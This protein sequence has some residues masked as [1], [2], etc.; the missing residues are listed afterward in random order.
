MKLQNQELSFACRE[1]LDSLSDN[2]SYEPDI[3]CFH[4]I[5]TKNLDKYIKEILGWFSVPYSSS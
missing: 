3:R 5:A 2:Q 4:S 1:R